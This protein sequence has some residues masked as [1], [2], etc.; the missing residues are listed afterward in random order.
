[1]LQVRSQAELCHVLTG[2]KVVLYPWYAAYGSPLSL[3]LNTCSSDPAHLTVN[4]LPRAAPWSAT[5]LF[6]GHT[7]AA[8]THPASLIIIP[9]SP[10]LPLTRLHGAPLHLQP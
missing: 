5:H 9:L 2:G 3:S 1:M 4:P 10:Q 7:F 6:Y 8:L